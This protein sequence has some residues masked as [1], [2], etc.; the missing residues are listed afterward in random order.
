MFEVTKENYHT[1]LTWHGMDP[2]VAEYV[3]RMHDGSEGYNT[4]KSVYLWVEASK[5]VIGNRAL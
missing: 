2:E 3:I 1:F 4:L 5:F